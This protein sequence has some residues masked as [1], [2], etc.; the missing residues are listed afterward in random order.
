MDYGMQC[1]MPTS[2]FIMNNKHP[3]SNDQSLSWSWNRVTE[4]VPDTNFLDATVDSPM[5]LQ[6]KWKFKSTVE[7]Q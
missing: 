1:N 2:I 3:V 7:T 5:I 6:M 4:S